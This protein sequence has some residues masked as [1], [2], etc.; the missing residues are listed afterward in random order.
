MNFK[1]TENN[2]ENATKNAHRNRRPI[3]YRLLCATNPTAATEPRFSEVRLNQAQQNEEDAEGK[4][5]EWLRH[6]NLLPP[7]T[8]VP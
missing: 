6:G 3:P 4:K 8:L 7:I 2:G 5:N 1:K